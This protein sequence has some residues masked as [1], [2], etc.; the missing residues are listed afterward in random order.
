MNLKFRKISKEEIYKNVRIDRLPTDV[1]SSIPYTNVFK[2]GVIET[3]K[4][5]FTKQYKMKDANFSISQMEKQASIFEAYQAFLNT[6]TDEYRWS[7]TIHNH[8][9]DKVQA[10]ENIKIDPANDGLNLYRRELNQMYAQKMMA[11]TNNISQNK[12]L[13]VAIDSK[14]VDEA[15][16]K[17][18]AIDEEIKKALKKVTGAPLKDL[19]I[20]K[21]LNVLYDI[22][23][24]NSKFRFFNMRRD[25]RLDFSLDV[26]EKQGISSKDCI[27]P[28]SFDFKKRNHFILGDSTYGQAFKLTGVPEY[29]SS[30][31]LSDITNLPFE[32][33]VTLTHEP[34]PVD[35]TYKLVK[36]QLV[37][38]DAQ[39]ASVN[40]KNAEDGYGNFLPP[41]LE[42]AQ[43]KARQLLNDV[44]ARNQKLTYI[45]VTIVIFGRSFDEMNSHVAQLKQVCA[46]HQCII[47]MAV[48]EQ[49]AAFNTALPLC[50]NQIYADRLYTTESAA[51]YVPYTSQDILQEDALY[52]GIN[53][54]T[55]NL[56]L[57][58]R[59]ANKNYN[60][61]VFGES[62][63]G[64]SFACKLEMTSVLLKHPNSQVFVIDPENEYGDL[65]RALN[66]LQ[67]NLSAGSK[68]RINPLDMDMGY[69]ESEEGLVD[70]IPMKSQ[71]IVSLLELMTHSRNGLR[72]QETAIL[73]RCVRQ[74]YKGY[75]EHMEKDRLPLGITCDEQKSPTLTTLYN[76]LRRQP[77]L[78]A[79]N[80]ATVLE[81]YAN[82]SFNI[83][84]NK[85]NVSLDSKLVV[86]NINGLGAGLKDLGLQICLNDIW[87]RTIQNSKKGIY[88]WF[89]ID[90]FYLLLRSHESANFLMEI[91]KRARKWLG[92]PTG[93]MQNTE[94]LLG[95]REG[96]AIMNNSSFVFMLPEP[97]HD[98]MNLMEMLNLSEDQLEYITE[99]DTDDSD[100]VGERTALLY[101][102]KLA[103]PIITN[104]PTDLSL[105]S[106]M[107]TTYGKG[108][109]KDERTA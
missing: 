19:S 47:R 25:E 66:G 13:T 87:N 57:Y 89:Y 64:K 48:Y 15:M 27:G 21:R 90:E 84:S 77:E 82:G 30:E 58:N 54:T 96:R 5:T 3:N 6:F 39:V 33:L 18:N 1:I 52:Y 91:W 35:K 92:V 85:T 49:E 26:L 7:V 74:M 34:C 75:V 106:L 61:L 56:V 44:Q 46:K 22:Y 98:R 67:I 103:L 45:T 17:L 65:C 51:V 104:F 16:L 108:A 9:I 50:L 38:I 14:N 31:F 79:Q 72:P 20:E 42:R 107:N 109:S 2:N 36:D 55:K 101:N 93:I 37:A 40:Q 69:A 102:N 11:G 81:P 105:F 4:G 29:L 97:Y 70:P 24:Q 76:L 86:Y 32:M 43:E 71:Y 63:S 12:Y 53:A 68:H 95:T 41:D 80:L 59:L 73:D 23:N 8:Q 94:D 10:M 88:T 100:D 62:G 60:G 78:E 28:D 99:P 83:F